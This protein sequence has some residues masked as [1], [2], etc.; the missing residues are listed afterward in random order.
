MPHETFHEKY[1]RTAELMAIQ[2]GLE[3]CRPR[4]LRLFSDPYAPLLVSFRWRLVLRAARLGLARRVVERLYDSPAGPWPRASAVARTRLIDDM[5]AGALDPA[6]QPVILGAGFDSRAYRLDALAQTTV[7]EVD[8][9]A[10]QAVK[11][12]RIRQALGE[13]AGLIH[14]VPVDFERD[15]LAVALARAGFDRAAPSI[16]LW[17]GVTN[18]L[19]PSA[20]DATLAAIRRSMSK[21]SSLIFTYVHEDA[22]RPDSNTFPEAARWRQQVSRRGEPW[23]FGLRPAELPAFLAARGFEV[24]T[25]QSTA[26]AGARYFEPMGRRNRASGLYHVALALAA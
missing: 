2:R 11:R 1:S 17:E 9:P 3:D 10:T 8:Q 24:V 13:R 19:T 16:F 12:E 15:D 20:V 18:Y 21:R 7:Y 14:F 6:T 25:D 5:L 26:D 4:T 22:L 23:I